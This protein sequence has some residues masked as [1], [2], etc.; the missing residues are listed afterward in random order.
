MLILVKEEVLSSITVIETITTP[1]HRIK[2]K[3][4]IFRGCQLTVKT[5]SKSQVPVLNGRCR[6]RRNLA[7]CFLWKTWKILILVHPDNICRYLRL[8][9]HTQHDGNTNQSMKIPWQ[10]F[11]GSYANSLW[12]L[13]FCSQLQSPEHLFVCKF[14]KNEVRLT[15]T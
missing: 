8:H 14:L 3:A 11:S 13:N 1:Q 5:N 12:Y 15:M 7:R 2:I 6:S 4:E 9:L 10:S